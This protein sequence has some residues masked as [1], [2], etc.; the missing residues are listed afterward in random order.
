MPCPYANILGVPG[1]GIHAK[2]IFGLAFNDLAMTIVAA[3]AISYFYNISFLLSF[4]FLFV[5]GEIL[6]YFFGVKTAYLTMIGI[7]PSCDV[8]CRS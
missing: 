6:H 1:E 5:L 7:D 8:K 3:I 4:L 2:R